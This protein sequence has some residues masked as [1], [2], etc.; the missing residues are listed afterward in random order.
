MALVVTPAN[1]ARRLYERKGFVA[2][3]TA[4]DATYERL[5]GVGGRVLMEKRLAS[6]SAEPSL[7]GLV[8]GRA[9][10]IEEASQAVRTPPPD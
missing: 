2:T 9:A 3:C 1:P 4:L 6:S 8:I 10:Q 5:T 7:D